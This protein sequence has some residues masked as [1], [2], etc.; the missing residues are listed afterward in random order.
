MKPNRPLPVVFYKSEKNNEPAR[1]WLKELPRDE[2]KIIGE[3]IK[4]VQFGWPI[5][6]PLIKKIEPD[7]W[8]V[9][10][11]LYSRIARIILTVHNDTIILLHGFIKKSQKIPASDKRLAKQRLLKMREVHHDK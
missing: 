2:R 4:T 6:M 1:D 5:G 11:K 8:E 10:S 9:R 7:L 3:N